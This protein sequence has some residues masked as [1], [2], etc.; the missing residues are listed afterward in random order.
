MPVSPIQPAPVIGLTDATAIAS[1]SNRT[2][3]VRATG[4]VVCWGMDEGGLGGPAEYSATPV[5][6]VGLSGAVDVST[7]RSSCA[8]RTDGT[9]ACWGIFDNEALQNV[10]GLTGAVALGSDGSDCVLHSDGTATCWSPSSGRSGHAA[11][12]MARSRRW[13]ALTGHQDD[14]YPG[15]ALHVDASVS[16]F[17]LNVAGTLADGV[18]DFATT[19]SPSLAAVGCPSGEAMPAPSDSTP[20]AGD[21]YARRTARVRAEPHPGVAAAVV[22][23]VL[24]VAAAVRAARAGRR[25]LQR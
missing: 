25:G 16:C 20:F 12:L 18:P 4:V 24:P 2:C 3:A 13:I 19:P 9:A 21:A 15:C 5:T 10:P 23:P 1:G 6:V 11:H 8:I 17:G 7:A 14:L 22:E